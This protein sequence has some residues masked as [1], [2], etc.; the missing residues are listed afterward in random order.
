M[1]N[2]NSKAFTLV[3][4]IVVIVILA[5]LWT[6]AFISLQWYSISARNSVRISDFKNIEL[7][8]DLYNTKAWKYPF[9]DNYLEITSNWTVINYQWYVWEKILS[10]LWISNWSKDPLDKTYYSYMTNSNISKYQLMWFLEGWLITFNSLNLVNA[11]DLSNRTPIIKWSDLWILTDA[12]NTPIQELLTWS[13][14]LSSNNTEYVM[15]LNNYTLPKLEWDKLK[16]I[17]ISNW[18]IKYNAPKDC[19]KWFIWVPWNAQFNQLWFCVAKYEMSWHW[20]TGVDT[21]WNTYSYLDNWDK[22]TVVSEQWNSPIAEITQLQ[23]IQECKDMWEWYHLITNNERM[24]IARNIELFYSNWSNWTVW[25]W[26]I[27]NGI[28]EDLVLGCTWSWITN[29]P[30]WGLRGTVTWHNICG[31]KNKLK[32]SNWEEIWDLAWNLYEHV[33]KANTIDWSNYNSWQTI[34][35]WSSEWE[36]R[37]IDWIYNYTD[38]DKYGSIFHYWKDKWMWTIYYADWVSSNTFIRGA[39]AFHISYTG[40]FSLW[41]ALLDSQLYKTIGF[42]CA[43]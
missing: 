41:L 25:Y 31:W 38:M 37:D 23:A 15:H 4:L 34:V 35:S 33:N 36:D 1:Q 12:N 32:L 13:L 24:T 16:Y 22:W 17:L 7:W 8:L 3:E 40:I 6:I 10:Q 11:I 27:Y 2:K 9:P 14:E 43:K 18:D 26:Y 20:I 29:L 42:R 19:P 39:W 21:W 28:S 5:I 30:T